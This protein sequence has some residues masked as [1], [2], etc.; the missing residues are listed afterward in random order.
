M[1][2]DQDELSGNGEPLD[3]FNNLVTIDEVPKC[4]RSWNDWILSGNDLIYLKLTIGL[5]DGLD[6]MISGGSES[7]INL[8]K[9]RHALI[10]TCRIK[11]ALSI[12][13]E[14][15]RNFKGLKSSVI[16]SIVKNPRIL[17]QIGSKS[18]MGPAGGG[19]YVQ[20]AAKM[21][22][23]GSSGE[24]D[25]LKFDIYEGPRQLTHLNK[26]CYK[27]ALGQVLSDDTFAFN[28]YWTHLH[29][30]FHYLRKFGN[31]E[32]G[33]LQVSVKLGKIYATELPR[34]F[35]EQT[36]S[37]WLAR[38]ALDKTFKS[39]K[40]GR[41]RP[42]TTPTIE[43]DLSGLKCNP[44]S[45]SCV[46]ET[47][48]SNRVTQSLQSV[49]EAA[50]ATET[51]GAEAEEEVQSKQKQKKKSA[52]SKSFGKMSTSFEPFVEESIA[53]RLLSL[54]KFEREDTLHVSLTCYDETSNT[55][56]SLQVHYNLAADG[57]CENLRSISQR[58]LRWAVTD[59]LSLSSEN[60]KSSLNARISV[61]SYNQNQKTENLESNIFC[62]GLI[63]SFNGT[64]RVCE[65]FRSNPTIYARV[66]EGYSAVL[67][68]D[69][70]LV[71]RKISESI[72]V[73]PQ[74]GLF[75]VNQEKW[76]VEAKMTLDWDEIHDY[77]YR[78]QL[79]LT[80]WSI[81]KSLKMII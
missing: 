27:I 63:E 56:T 7:K 62:D 53:K 74:S 48:S 21:V 41:K 54:W 37:I 34:M 70:A 22:F 58:G 32:Y 59:V 35:M 72:G 81:C 68:D 14:H 42:S 73:D 43:M 51:E 76:E 40:W 19:V 25:L 49:L 55:N 69:F 79:I 50:T 26:T 17:R 75:A 3:S 31:P 2:C 23:I 8:L 36:V 16:R 80:M 13:N 6:G 39:S 64:L 15:Y 77:Q 46:D 66:Q 30:Q 71:I 61:S 38:V 57:K 11:Y 10:R 52:S 67:R 60:E 78:D 65:K 20:G 33:E 29:R 44:R 5:I 12:A 45:D 47:I 9:I 28:E 18:P 1:K 4:L 24:A